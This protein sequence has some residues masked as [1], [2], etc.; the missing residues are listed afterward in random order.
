MNRMLCSFFLLSGLSAAQANEVGVM[1]GQDFS[2]GT[3]GAESES[4]IGV[5][6]FGARA[7]FGQWSFRASTG[8]V[9]LGENPD[10][11][12]FGPRGGELIIPGGEV[13]GFTDLNFGFSGPLVRETERRP[14]VTLT[15]SIKL[16]T[17]DEQK[18]LG[19]GAAD[20][21]G[22]VEL[23][24]VIGGVIGY[25]YLGGRIRGESDVIDV[26]NSVNAG[27]GVQKLLGKKWIGAL[28]YDYRGASFV[29][30]EDAQEITA[31]ISF[32]ATPG[33]SFSAYTYTGFTDVSP[34]LGFG[35]FWSQR[36]REW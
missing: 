26:Q 30:G 14:A 9:D 29:N 5:T 28:S 3:Y 33:T 10:M 13:S 19:T 12:L 17:A 24:K 16:P 35:I 36:L 11:V 34:D 2:Q 6:S 22:S 31:L 27:L 7:R 21:G 4:N 1:I 25:T 23:S 8:Y 15:G 32:Q 18:G 20:F